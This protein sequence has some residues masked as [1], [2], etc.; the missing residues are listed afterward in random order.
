[1][2]QKEYP[3]VTEE[4]SQKIKKA[5]EVDHRISKKMPHPGLGGRIKGAILNEYGEPKTR[6]NLS[7]TPTAKLIFKEWAE[8]YDLTVADVMERLARSSK[9]LEFATQELDLAGRSEE[10]KR[11]RQE[12]AARPEY[13]KALKYKKAS[14]KK[15]K[16]K[17][18]KK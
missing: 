5:A 12:A 17:R 8:E 1:M 4:Q 11:I 10:V 16:K 15:K 7:V 9:C 14:N 3:R 2:S 13:Q 6:L 18:S